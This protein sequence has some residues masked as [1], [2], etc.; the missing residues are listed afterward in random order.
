LSTLVENSTNANFNLQKSPQTTVIETKVQ[1]KIKAI[2]DLSRIGFSGV[3]VKKYNQDNLFIFKNFNDESENIFMSVCDGHGM[4]GHEVS[5][6]LKEHL[7]VSLNNEFKNKKLSLSDS[8]VNKVI[9]EVFVSLNS[10]LFNDATMDTN[11]SGSTCVS[12]IYSPEKIICA[13]VGDSRAVLGRHI[14]GSKN[15]NL[16]FT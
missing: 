7:P 9:E 2:Y 3:G 6:Y 16:Y 13:N 12:V 5:A 14:N 8:K 10:R 1:K 4:W 15:N 11:F